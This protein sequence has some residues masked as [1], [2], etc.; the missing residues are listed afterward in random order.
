MKKFFKSTR[1]LLIIAVAIIVIDQITK[2]FV[3]RYIPFGGQWA[4]WDWMLPYARLLHI[5]N[6]GAAFGLFKDANVIL[7]I[8]AVV[9][10]AAI[11]WY[12]PR[13][14]EDQKVV[15]FALSLQL[16]GA[17]G[18]LIDRIAFGHVTDFISVGN[19]AIFNV[20]DSSI[21]VGVLILLLAVWWQD[22]KEKQEKTAVEPQIPEK[23]AGSEH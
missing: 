9:V 23:E 20:A 12:Y 5:S 13:V 6:T 16:A 11:L 2:Y 4:P 1:W 3:R 8:L 7:M 14:P 18:N 10:S 22:R 17:L 15:R 21:T 19:F